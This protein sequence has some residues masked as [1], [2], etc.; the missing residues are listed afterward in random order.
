MLREFVE[1]RLLI[2]GI[3]LIVMML[4]RP[5]GLWPSAVRRRELHAAETDELSVAATEAP[6]HEEVQPLV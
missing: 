5:E 4:V 2:Y 1:F 6:L 3:L